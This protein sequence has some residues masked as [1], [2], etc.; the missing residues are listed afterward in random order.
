MVQKNQRMPFFPIFEEKITSL[1]P[2][3]CK[4]T[5][6]LEKHTALMPN[7]CR[8]KVHS[9]KK[10]TLMLFA[11]NF[12]WKNPCCCARIWS[13]SVEA[14]KPFFAI[15]HEKSMLSCSDF[16]KK[17]TFSKTHCY[18]QHDLKKKIQSFKNTVLLCYFF[19]TF[20]EKTHLV[21]PIFGPKNFNSSSYF[22]VFIG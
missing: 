17:R 9:L 3:S 7:F 14:A 12:S 22:F 21:M 6:F 11:T 19:Q 2:I 1:I 15:F 10:H 4:K 5:P 18:L 8:K 16:V 20:H 13:K